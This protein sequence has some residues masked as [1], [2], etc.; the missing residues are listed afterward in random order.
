MFEIAVVLVQF[1]EAAVDV[2]LKRQWSFMVMVLV[3]TRNL[4]PRVNQRGRKERLQ[5]E[6]AKSRPEEERVEGNK[7]IL[8]EI[9][10]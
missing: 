2:K 6:E 3:E 8:Y 10:I 9:S 4:D 5:Q 1:S 7:H